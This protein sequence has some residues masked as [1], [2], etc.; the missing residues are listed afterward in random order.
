MSLANKNLIF[1]K[2]FSDGKLSA[3]IISH[4]Q[5]QS[6]VQPFERRCFVSGLGL[7]QRVATRRHL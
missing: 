4:K 2:I 7:S 1:I 3:G 5:L 6:A